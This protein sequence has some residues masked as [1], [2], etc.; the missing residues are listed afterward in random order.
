M[1]IILGAT[2]Y[3]NRGIKSRLSRKT[4]IGI[5]IV[6]LIIN[7]VLGGI[8]INFLWNTGLVLDPV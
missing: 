6:R 5:T 3:L 1:L 7:P 2:L 8:L 4:L